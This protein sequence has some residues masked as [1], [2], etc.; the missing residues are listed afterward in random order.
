MPCSTRAAGELPSSALP[1]R[2]GPRRDLPGKEARPLTL[3]LCGA[4]GNVGRRIDRIG[5]I[6]RE[7]LDRG[8]QVT[9]VVRDPAPATH[10]DPRLTIVQG[11]ATDATSGSPRALMRC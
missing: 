11:D 5:R 8:H 9:A 4:G 10:L 3:V 6:A 1:H 2:R 7:A